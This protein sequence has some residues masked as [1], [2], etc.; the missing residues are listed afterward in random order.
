MAIIT[1]ANEHD[2][3]SPQGTN[4]LNSGDP[5]GQPHNNAPSDAPEP[6]NLRTGGTTRKVGNSHPPEM[7]GIIHEMTE[8]IIGSVMHQ[9]REQIPQL[10][11]ENLMEVSSVREDGEETYTHTPPVRRNQEPIKGEQSRHKVA[12]AGTIASD[13]QQDF[14]A[15]LR[16]QVDSLSVR[17]S[18]KTRRGTDTKLAGWPLSSQIT[19]APSCRQG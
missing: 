17:V 11:G 9:L 7:A 18:G 1:K 2:D 15:A 8:T 3:N 10:R 14:M 19:G 12:A 4:G 6:I 5:H 16:R 13:P